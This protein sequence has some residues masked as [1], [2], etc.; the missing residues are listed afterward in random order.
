MFGPAHSW[1]AG[2]ATTWINSQ[3][4]RQRLLVFLALK[5]MTALVH[6]LWL[7]KLGKV[8][9]SLRTWQLFASAIC[10]N[11]RACSVRIGAL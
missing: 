6:N 1:H 4:H 10:N 2:V 11:R 9:T 8:G 3:Q 5:L 7:D